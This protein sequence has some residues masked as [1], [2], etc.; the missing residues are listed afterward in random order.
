MVTELR[1]D[2]IGIFSEEEYDDLGFLVSRQG[3]SSTGSHDFHRYN[4]SQSRRD[5]LDTIKHVISQ[6]VFDTINHKYSKILKTDTIAHIQRRIYNSG[7]HLSALYNTLFIKD[8]SL[9][10]YVGFCP[11]SLFYYYNICGD[12]DS[13]I[14][15]E[16]KNRSRA[17]FEYQT[18]GVD[19]KGEQTVQ[20]YSRRRPEPEIWS[21]N[22][23]KKLTSIV[24]ESRSIK[25]EYRNDE[26][27][28][29]EEVVPEFNF[30][31][32]K[33]LTITTFYKY[34]QAGLR[35][36]KKLYTTGG[37]KEKENVTKIKRYKNG[38]PQNNIDGYQLQY[39]YRLTK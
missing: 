36:I 2:W 39:S 21:F 8:W 24:Y 26:I 6:Q 33:D 38:L 15:Y 31:Q 12:R 18:Q 5:V 37:M 7:N 10:E 27:I 30:S 19:R 20:V 28:R 3:F 34:N 22:P 11:D 9:T 23:D 13:I 16:G 32:R 17:Y 14:W 1:K 29:I 4:Y 25:Y 35:K